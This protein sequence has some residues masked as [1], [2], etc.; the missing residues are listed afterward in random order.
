MTD[1]SEVTTAGIRPELLTEVGQDLGR[2]DLSR[3]CP[4]YRLGGLCDDCFPPLERF[5]GLAAGDAVDAVA[6]LVLASEHK[7]AV[8]SDPPA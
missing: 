8:P 1:E 3:C 5:C 6:V 4:S 7:K 2:L